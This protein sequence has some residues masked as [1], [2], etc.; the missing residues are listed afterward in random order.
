MAHFHMFFIFFF[1]ELNTKRA[2]KEGC[3]IITMEVLRTN[4]EK[5]LCP[6]LIGLLLNLT[7]L[8]NYNYKVYLNCMYYRYIFKIIFFLS[9][10]VI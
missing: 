4:I 6:V 7:H 1:L 5:K 2:L 10:P 3:L 9:L 8:D